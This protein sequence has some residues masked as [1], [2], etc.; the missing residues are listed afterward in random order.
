MR[1]EVDRNA[2]LCFPRTADFYHDSPAKRLGREGGSAILS[3]MC[4]HHFHATLA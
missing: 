3:C 1:G 4:G 2:E